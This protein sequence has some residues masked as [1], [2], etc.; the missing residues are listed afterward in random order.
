[1]TL[2]ITE[3]VEAI[4]RHVL[5]YEWE[6]GSPSSPF[7]PRTLVS[8]CLV[9][10][11]WRN[12]MLPILWSVDNTLRKNKV[13]LEVLSEYRHYV[14]VFELPTARYVEPPMYTQLRHLI[15]GPGVWSG[16][17]AIRLI[18]M[19]FK[20]VKLDVGNIRLDDEENEGYIPFINHIKVDNFNHNIHTL[21]NPLRHLKDTL[22]EFSMSR[23]DIAGME[24]YYWLQDIAQ[25]CL[26]N[27]ELKFTR[28]TFDLQD[29]VF[30]SL[31]RLRL[32]LSNRLDNGPH[33]IIGRSPRL[34]YLILDIPG[35]EKYT[36]LEELVL[37]LRGTPHPHMS[38]RFQHWTRP[39]LI[40]LDLRG[41]HWRTKQRGND[42]E[43][44]D[45]EYLELV[46]A[47]IPTHT[48]TG[49]PQHLREL[50]LTLWTIDEDARTVIEI[51][52]PSLERLVI[53]IEKRPWGDPT[54]AKIKQQLHVVRTILQSCPRLKEFRLQDRNG[55]LDVS[56]VMATLL[57]D[58]GKEKDGATTGPWGCS[59]LESLVLESRNVLGLSLP[60]EVEERRYLDDQGDR[61]GGLNEVGEWVVPR[62]QWNTLEQD[63]TGFLLGDNPGIFNLMFRPKSGENLVKRFLGY[64]SQSKKLKEV[65]LAQ[66]KFVRSRS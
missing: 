21:A 29:I 24:L 1:P 57:E 46:R 55:N 41:C 50:Y 2:D 63:G 19:N 4:G 3:L 35:N 30:E 34:E 9:S 25:G 37:V 14:R 48:S 66:L 45:D 8:C 44:N 60:T 43:V 52:S 51:H 17:V 31:T 18:G 42:P 5:V 58:N 62:F 64:L 16:R 23:D 6:S 38:Y 32:Y 22:Q 28:C 27:L 53:E 11:H 10:R 65:Q 26:W 33:E 36:Q 59:E 15:M 40:S 49:Q 20:L 39:K 7:Q 54:T 47:C 13:P 61:N 12:V 56:V